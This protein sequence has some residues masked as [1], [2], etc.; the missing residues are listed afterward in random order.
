[1]PSAMSSFRM[2]CE[3]NWFRYLYGTSHPSKHD[4][5]PVSNSADLHQM[6]DRL[7][8]RMCDTISERP[9]KILKY[10]KISQEII[11]ATKNPKKRTKHPKKSIKN[12]L[13][14]LIKGLLYRVFSS[15]LRFLTFRIS[16]FYEKSLKIPKNLE[17]SH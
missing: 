13:N 1:M 9:R 2:P 6:P 3:G 16:L 17:K 15:K 4:V 5:E 12:R 14:K 7:L 10:L 8:F 11:R